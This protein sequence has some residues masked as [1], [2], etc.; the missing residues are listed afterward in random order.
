MCRFLYDARTGILISDILDF[1]ILCFLDLSRKKIRQ[2]VETGSAIGEV[3]SM[4]QIIQRRIV[5]L[6]KPAL[7]QSSSSISV[8]TWLRSALVTIIKAKAPE[9]WRNRG[10][11]RTSAGS[12]HSH[13]HFQRALF[14]FAIKVLMR[15]KGQQGQYQPG[16]FVCVRQQGELIDHAEFIESHIRQIAFREFPQSRVICS[17]TAQD[18]FP[19]QK[20]CPESRGK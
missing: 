2:R 18:Q 15:S 19:F 17:Q 16:I 20:P 11:D 4:V 7:W 9:V 3:A 6:R 14:E 12:N 1:R 8:S 10:S 5:T 13:A